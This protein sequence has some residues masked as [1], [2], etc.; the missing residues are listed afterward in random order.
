MPLFQVDDGG[1]HQH[2]ER[3]QRIP[4]D[5]RRERHAHGR[6]VIA[7]RRRDVQV[8]RADR[9]DVIGVDID[10]AGS[11]IGGRAEQREGLSKR[12]SSAA[13]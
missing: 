8:S 12:S 13:L 4:V 3:K 2:R 6:V 11:W 9:E 5:A 1:I 7:E 10:G